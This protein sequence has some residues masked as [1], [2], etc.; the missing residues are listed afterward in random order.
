MKICVILMLLNQNIRILPV[1]YKHVIAKAKRGFTIFCTFNIT[2]IP[3]GQKLISLYLNNIL[4]VLQQ[5]I[6]G[7]IQRC[8]PNAI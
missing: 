5:C 4:K 3:Y 6:L 8:S 7:K 1:Y 2:E